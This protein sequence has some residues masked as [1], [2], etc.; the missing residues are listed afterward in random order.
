M[1]YDFDTTIADRFVNL[2][3]TFDEGGAGFDPLDVVAIDHD[4][5]AALPGEWVVANGK[6]IEEALWLHW[7]SQAERRDAARADR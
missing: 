6:A 4:A 2:S 3:G 7:A 5:D 1:T